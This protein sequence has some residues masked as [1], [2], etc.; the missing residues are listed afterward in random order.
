MTAPALNPE[1]RRFRRITTAFLE[2]SHALFPQDAS[3]LGL[4]RFDAMLGENTPE[5]HL[6]YTRLLENALRDVEALP[7]IAFAGDDWL[8]RR[9]FL[10]MVRTG[11]FFNRDFPHWRINP[12]T[13]CDTAI[14]SIFDLVVRHTEDLKKAL[15]PIESRL[16]KVPAFLSGGAACVKEPVPLWTKLA[17]QSCDG[18][19]DFLK[20]LE[21]QLLPLSAK[22]AHTK[23]LFADA[24]AAFKAYARSIGNK[25]QGRAGGFS[26]G[27]SNFEFMIRERLGLSM[28]L[29][30]AEALGRKLV[31]Q[32]THQQKVEAAKFGKRKAA[33]IIEEAAAQWKP[34][35]ATLLDEYKV[36]TGRMRGKFA[37]AGLLTLPR[38]EK[39]KVLPVP[40]FMQHQ[41]PTAAYSQPG[42]FDPDQT[43]IFWVNDLSLKQKT[44]EKRAAEV[45]QH[46]GLELTCA[47]EA[48]PGHHVQ[49]VIQNQHA[50]K[51][52]RLFHHAIFYEG[53]T[54]WCEKMCIEQGI[55]DAPHARLVQ[56]TDA[57]WRAYRIL[58]DCGLHSGAL[59][60]KKAC[61]VLM[62]GVGFTEGRARG[63]VNWY[64]SSPTV[65][66]SYLIG[67]I[68]LEKMH[69][70]L[71]TRSGWPLKKFNDWIL[72]YGAIPWS[73][74]WQS[75]LGSQNLPISAG[76]G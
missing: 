56:T 17:A 36:V 15:P 23:R 42:A 62:D 1:I 71:V 65:P 9:G 57:L 54:L 3:A 32:L 28:S 38:G 16:A 50:S 53:W 31:E 46:Y 35:A 27:R 76:R 60:Y 5:V 4:H 37:K 64:T 18:A 20:K 30:E 11:L 74:I 45:R 55:Y 22:P 48:Y 72:S 14:Q 49:F 6:Q 51:V 25:K 69:D 2:E 21:E 67:R 7:E 8:D 63:D 43:G 12:Q 29:P 66:M 41:F 52:R 33:T 73:W 75:A 39:L 10:A 47:H 24:G 19:L 59:D 44:L 40:E 70:K 58:I 34:G 61:R 26:I 68:E 13:H